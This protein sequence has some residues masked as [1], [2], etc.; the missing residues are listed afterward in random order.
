M[1]R[2]F[3]VFVI[4]ILVILIT[5][6][7]YIQ[8]DGGVVIK[9][10]PMSEEFINVIASLNNSEN[11][12]DFMRINFVFAP[13]KG[14]IAQLP[15]ET[16]NRREGS[17]QDLAAFA[18]YVLSYHN[19]E[20]GIIRYKFNGNLNTV[21]IFR[22]IDAPKYIYFDETGASIVEHGMSFRDLIRLEEERLGVEI[23]EYAVFPSQETNF[24]RGDWI[25]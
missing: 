16:L 4:V 14:E 24:S 25:Q 9:E 23:E 18:G 21:V 5:I 1:N 7:Y 15:E 8:Q 13:R 11:L 20:T 22:D 10:E 3:F 19:F 12:R 2:K 6:F 17:D